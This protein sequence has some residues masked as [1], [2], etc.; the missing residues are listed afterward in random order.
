MHCPNGLSTPST[1]CTEICALHVRKN[2]CAVVKSQC[3]NE[4]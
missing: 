4:R 3:T 2:I 1:F